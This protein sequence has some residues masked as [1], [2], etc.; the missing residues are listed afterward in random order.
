LVAA[1]IA[2]QGVGSSLATAI[3]S[4]WKGKLSLPPRVAA[5][6]ANPISPALRLENV[7]RLVSMVGSMRR[8][9]RRNG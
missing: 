7:D 9:Q 8:S 4:D 1:I 3:G 5:A 6:A 2:H